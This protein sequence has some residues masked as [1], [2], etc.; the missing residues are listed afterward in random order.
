M[1]P[2]HKDLQRRLSMASVPKPPADLADRIKRDIP[3]AMPAR[4]HR[5]ASAFGMRIAASILLV[6]GAAWFTLRLFTRAG[7]EHEISPAMVTRRKEAQVSLPAPGPQTAEAG[8]MSGVPLPAPPPA[9]LEPSATSS[10]A[11][12]ATPD[13]QRSDDSTRRFETATNARGDQPVAN[14]SP[15]APQAIADAG[16]SGGALYAAKAVEEKS[17]PAPESANPSPVVAGSLANETARRSAAPMLQTAPAHQAAPPF[18]IPSGEAAFQ[19]VKRAIERG[20]RPHEVNVAALVN[21]FAGSAATSADP[22]SLEAELSKGPVAAA[23][24]NVA[25]LRISV[26]SRHS[27]DG[28]AVARDIRLEIDPEPAAVAG[29]H[30]VPGARGDADGNGPIVLAESSLG[31]DVSTTMLYR[32]ELRTPIRRGTIASVRLSFRNASGD[33]RAVTLTVNGSQIQRPWLLASR[34]QRLATLGAVWADDLRAQGGRGGAGK[35]AA[36]LHEGQDVARR[37]EELAAQEPADARARELAAL[38]SASSRLQN[39]GPTG[40]AR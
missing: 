20:E 11:A 7:T 15:A 2:R 17:E 36:S 29:I 28:A 14:G 31:P 6:V 25:L 4:T 26:D 39:S 34:R 33:P 13:E 38:A 37:A 5:H 16:T 9:A 24:D 35:T 1:N 40:S 10:R 27:G 30:P 32:L 12:A 22:L 21:Y 23:A 3:E 18:G 19:E 8:P